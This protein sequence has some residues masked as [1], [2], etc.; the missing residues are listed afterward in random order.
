[1]RNERKDILLDFMNPDLR[2]VWGIQR[3]SNSNID[4]CLRLIAYSIFLTKERCILP[5]NFVIQD[6]LSF[7]LT[8]RIYDYFGS[9]LISLPLKYSESF[10]SKAEKLV[11]QYRNVKNNYSH[12]K[13]TASVEKVIEYLEPLNH[14]RV[15]K[16]HN[17]GE[18]IANAF[19]KRLDLKDSYW[20]N[21]LSKYRYEEFSAL[22]NVPTEIVNRELAVTHGEIESFLKS[23]CISTIDIHKLVHYEYGCSYMEEYDAVSLFNFLGTSTFYPTKR[24]SN[25]AYDYR[26]FRA[27]LH[28]LGLA[29]PVDL[30]TPK[31]IISL[32]YS[33]NEFNTFIETYFNIVSM[34]NEPESV[35]RL[36]QVIISANKDLASQVKI[37]SS[38]LGSSVE[39]IESTCGIFNLVSPG[40]NIIT[41]H[42]QQFVRSG[43]IMKKIAIFVALREEEE[44]LSNSLSLEFDHD[45]ERY[46]KVMDGVTCE[47]YS[48]RKMGRVYAAISTYK[49]LIENIEKLPDMLIIAGIA[50]GFDKN[51]IKRGDILLPS[52]VYD[53]AVTK[54]E[55]STTSGSSYEVYRP[56]PFR[57]NKHALDFIN[58]PKFNS[59]LWRTIAK[60][61]ARRSDL[62]I[63]IHTKPM[64]CC[65]SVIKD[66]QWIENILSVVN[67]EMTGVDMETGGVCLALE[68]LN[69]TKPIP[70]SVI[71]GVSDLSNPYKADDEWRSKAMYTVGSMIKSVIFQK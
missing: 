44:I 13:S 37:N 49:Y 8:S 64:C 33:S 16:T 12:L 19:L 70:I 53:V 6:E 2:E 38:Q 60:K 28:A 40:F 41:S 1:M 29:E 57:I 51:K 10:W 67:S 47:I 23:S 30:L 14:C 63:D 50:G 21:V 11:L 54:K 24:T 65:D 15:V 66:E 34:H 71:R 45:K 26:L 58:S 35:R 31:E 17:T 7:I 4:L 42:L 56:E 22:I 62:S 43:V 5:V 52:S 32:R 68:E 46:R 18:Y 69:L 3:V 20:V 59:D 48:P 36:I 39:K 55:G 61:E 25:P 9:D 27:T